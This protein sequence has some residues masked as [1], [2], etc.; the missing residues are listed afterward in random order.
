MKETLILLALLFLTGQIIAASRALIERLR[1]HKG[2][3]EQMLRGQL[4]RE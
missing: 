4:D 2:L 3:R 1:R